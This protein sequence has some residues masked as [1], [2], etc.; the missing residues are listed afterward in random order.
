MGNSGISP[1]VSGALM[2]LGGS[3]RSNP[4][5]AGMHRILRETGI[6]TVSIC[7]CTH[8]TAHLLVCTKR[9]L[10]QRLERD[11]DTHDMLA[12]GPEARGP[13]DRLVLWSS[14]PEPAGSG[15]PGRAT[16][17]LSPWQEEFPLTQP[18][19]L[20][21]SPRDSVCPLTLEQVICFAQSTDQC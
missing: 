4:T 17:R 7:V 21:R 14:C 15:D 11:E 20:S 8:T 13:A 19:V 18:L 6:P 3:E 5:V 1:R 10:L 12:A 16:L 9:L 2:L